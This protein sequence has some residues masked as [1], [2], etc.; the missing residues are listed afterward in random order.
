MQGIIIRDGTEPD[1][2]DGLEFD[3]RE[4]L[5]ALG[6]RAV[7]SRWRSSYLQY[8]S[9]DEQDISVLERLGAELVVSGADFVNGIDRL[10]QVIDG[11]FE[12]LDK[13]GRWVVIR[14]VDSSWWE[15]WSDDQSVL[16]TVRAKF[17][18]TGDAS[19]RA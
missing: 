12:A 2:P 8:V 5:A 3:L 6:K 17:R 11:E 4:V 13:N 14:A 9:R 18:T 15:V 16:E 7:E 1:G 10:L 19:P